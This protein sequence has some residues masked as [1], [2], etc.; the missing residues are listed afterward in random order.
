MLLYGDVDASGTVAAVQAP[1]CEHR[2]GILKPLQF[3]GDNDI[4]TGTTAHVSDTAAGLLNRVFS[5]DAVTAVLP[6]G[7][8]I[9]TAEVE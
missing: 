4:P 6:V 2:G 7:V 9:I 3:V 8:A 5:I 1:L